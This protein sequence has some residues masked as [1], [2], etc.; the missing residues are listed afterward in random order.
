[1]GASGGPGWAA[2]TDKCAHKS[3]AED[4]G[5]VFKLFHDID[6]EEHGRVAIVFEHCVRRLGTCSTCG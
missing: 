4:S 3:V 6:V 5:V 1:M 2:T